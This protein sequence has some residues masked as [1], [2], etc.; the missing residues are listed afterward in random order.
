MITIK[1]YGMLQEKFVKSRFEVKANAVREAIS[2]IAQT[3]AEE[4]LL[5]TCVMFVNNKPLRGA[6][7]LA[8]KL[9]DGDELALLP[10]ASGG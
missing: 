7:R 1:L 4:K 6:A 8:T 2:C 5:R 3:E 9:R 10:P